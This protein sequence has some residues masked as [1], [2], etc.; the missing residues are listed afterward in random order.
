MFPFTLHQLRIL[1]AIAA[2]QSFTKAA[3]TLYLSQPSLSKQLKI[4]EDSLGL[5]LINRNEKQ[6]FMTENGK[7]LL[8][9]SDRILA[10][11]EESCRAL[12]DLKNE[13]RGN[14]AIGVTQTIETYLFPKLFVFFTQKYPQITLNF[15][16]YSDE[17]LVK[18]IHEETI[19][20]AIV[21]ENVIKFRDP[22]ITIK[23]FVITQL[24]LIVSKFHPFTIKKKIKKNE[25]YSLEYVSLE[26]DLIEKIQIDHLLKQNKI[27]PTRLKTVA[28]LHSIDS[29]K[30]AVDLGLGS[31]FVP[32]WAFS[33][34]KSRKRITPIKIKNFQ[35]VQKFYIV[36]LNSRKKSE[37]FEFF[38]TELLKF[39]LEICS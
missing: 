36:L 38:Y 7:L 29:V 33:T 10:L 3:E 30:A 21:N 2:E 37:A 25:I 16:V 5:L 31:A 23:P 26:S 18:Y 35:I 14:L 6:R 1:R 8:K 20:I 22:K 11:C 12:N 15:Q 9:Y 34:D 4:L 17:I 39:K 24:D 13:E 27:N 28:R 32:T 19:D